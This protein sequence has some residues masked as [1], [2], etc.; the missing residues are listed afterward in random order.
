MPVASS[1][2]ED[3]LLLALE[4][5]SEGKRAVVPERLSRETFSTESFS[6]ATEKI[7]QKSRPWVQGSGIQGIGIGEKVSKE[8]ATG[9]LALRV[10]VE[11]KKP[12]SRVKKSCAK[13][14]QYSG[15]GGM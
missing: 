8:R 12:R 3:R 10:Y 11:K 14:C 2:L 9:E 7:R 4:F 15:G 13:T 1:V 5:V 6:I